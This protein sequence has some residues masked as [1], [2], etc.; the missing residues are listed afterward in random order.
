MTYFKV[1]PIYDNSAGAPVIPTVDD[2]FS[3][4]VGITPEHHEIHE[5]DA[6]Y[7]IR[8]A[9][10]NSAGTI[11]VRVATP[12]NTKW[13]HMLI[14]IEGALAGT[15]ELWEGTT[16]THSTTNAITPFNRNRNSTKTSALTICHT[17][18]GAEGA[19]AGLTKYF[20]AASV[21]GKDS[22][23]GGANSRSEFILKQNTAYLLRATSRAD[24]NAMSI[25]LDWYEHTDDN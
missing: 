5:G 18:G 23:G 16:K 19:A 4:L 17:P 3:A 21:S 24:N 6:Y 13:A 7:A 10:L 25:E 1:T 12:N 11:E 20:G 8:S 22:E 2:S 15:A 9:L 14:V